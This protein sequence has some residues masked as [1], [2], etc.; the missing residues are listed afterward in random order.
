MGQCL[1][2]LEQL[3]D[4]VELLSSFAAPANLNSEAD[5]A[6][7]IDHVQELEGVTLHCL[8]EIEVSR[9][10]VMWVFI[11]LQLF[12]TSATATTVSA[13]TASLSFP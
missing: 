7:F 10:H 6:A 12:A 11:A 1:L 8:V 13:P 5:S 4:R 2:E 3:P 9:L